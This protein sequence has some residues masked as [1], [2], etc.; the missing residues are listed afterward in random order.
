MLVHGRGGAWRRGREWVAFERD[1]PPWNRNTR[2]CK[3]FDAVVW[4]QDLSYLDKERYR[5]QITQ[6]VALAKE[7]RNGFAFVLLW[8]AFVSQWVAFVL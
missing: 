6:A 4:L 3:L 1:P 5:A 7:V 2:K 8:F